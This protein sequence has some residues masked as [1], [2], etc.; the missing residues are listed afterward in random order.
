MGGGEVTCFN[1][2]Y[3][4]NVA[5]SFCKSQVREKP[6]FKARYLGARKLHL[7]VRGTNKEMEADHVH[8]STD[9]CPGSSQLSQARHQALPLE[10]QRLDL[11]QGKKRPL[12][13]VI[14]KER[15]TSVPCNSVPLP[16]RYRATFR[17]PDVAPGQT[18][19]ITRRYP[20]WNIGHVLKPKATLAAQTIIFLGLACRAA[21]RPTKREK[22][23]ITSQFLNFHTRFPCY[24]GYYR[25]PFH[26]LIQ[27]YNYEADI[28]ICNLLMSCSLTSLC[29][30]FPSPRE[31][32]SGPNA[33]PDSVAAR[34]CHFTEINLIGSWQDVIKSAFASRFSRLSCRSR[35]RPL[36]GLCSSLH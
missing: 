15:A 29:L 18:W 19:Q 32:I 13:N 5:K 31:T 4:F 17:L 16:Q 10:E 36:A 25:L 30:L 8:N 35:P 28:A 11:K 27:G 23:H 7:P 9:D 34:M 3:S 1:L 12:R 33:R 24:Q 26:L 20:S 22:Q 14:A 6:T 2:I 21:L